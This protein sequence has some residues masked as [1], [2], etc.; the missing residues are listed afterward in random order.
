MVYTYRC[1]GI[2]NMAEN[3][4]RPSALPA[5]P[6]NVDSALRQ[7]ITDVIRRSSKKRLQIAQEL[8]ELLG[9]RVTEGMLN[10]FSSES[11]K[12]VR[13]PLAFSAALCEILDDDSVGLLGVRRECLGLLA[14]SGDSGAAA[15]VGS[16][17]RGWPR[18]PCRAP[19][20]NAARNFIFTVRSA[21]PHLNLVDARQKYVQETADE[22]LAMNSGGRSQCGAGLFQTTRRAKSSADGSQRSSRHHRT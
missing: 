21:A 22:L 14:K 15:L 19:S 1:S 10:D 7:L 13:F 8:T 9:T 17:P 6:P 20:A 4:G 11:K 3:P 12:A 5:T 16:T 2:P 18:R